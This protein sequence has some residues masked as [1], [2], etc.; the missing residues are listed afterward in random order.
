MEKTLKKIEKMYHLFG[1]CEGH[2]CKECNRLKK[3]ETYNYKKYYKCLNYGNSN[4]EATDWK[5]NNMACGMFNKETE[6][7]V[8]KI[9]IPAKQEKVK[10]E[11]EITIFD[12]MERKLGKEIQ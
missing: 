5:I 1:K 11:N 4:S 7:E 8:I 6:K 2:K 10:N 9:Y 12:Y 3:Y